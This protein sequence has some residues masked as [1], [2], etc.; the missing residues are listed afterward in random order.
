MTTRT[1][2]AAAIVGASLL[3]GCASGPV[4][5]TAVPEPAKAVELDRYVG[6]WYE[7]ARYENRF[8]RGCEG[9]TAE[10]TAR[11]DGSIDVV[12][13]CR[14][15]STGGKASEAEGHAT[16]VPGSNGTKLKVSFFWPFYG[17]YWVLDR[18]DDYDWAIVGEPEGEFL[19]IL[20]RDPTPGQAV[21]ERHLQRARE[22]G[23]DMEL[24]RI[25]QQPPA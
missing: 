15:G 7:L 11:P 24:V 1:R 20:S 18:G 4:G 9:V 3:S 2:L 17:D 25:T 23:Y 14:E 22:L 21:L 19:W 5:N 10:Y 13:T 16:V 8:E 12:N 6:R